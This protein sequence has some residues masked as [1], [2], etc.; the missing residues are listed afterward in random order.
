M[1]TI[2][3]ARRVQII[4]FNVN[5][6][7]AKKYHVIKGNVT[8]ETENAKNLEVQSCGVQSMMCFVP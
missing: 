1:K 7:S 6:D 3:N 4:V 5:G 2:V 8:Y